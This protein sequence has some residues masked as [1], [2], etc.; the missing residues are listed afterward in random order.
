MQKN[1][2]DKCIQDNKHSEIWCYLEQ[3]G[4]A[5]HQMRLSEVRKHQQMI[6]IRNGKENNTGK[7]KVCI[8]TQSPRLLYPITENK[9]SGDLGSQREKKFQVILF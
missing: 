2:P 3:K 7:S 1:I 5:A 8:K 6:Q 4:R 9:I